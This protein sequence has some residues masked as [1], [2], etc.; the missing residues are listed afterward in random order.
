MHECSSACDGNS[1]VQGSAIVGIREENW[2]LASFHIHQLN[3]TISHNELSLNSTIQIH[4]IQ[5]NLL[6]KFILFLYEA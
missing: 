4:C 1:P 6:I 2:W 5:Q 3:K